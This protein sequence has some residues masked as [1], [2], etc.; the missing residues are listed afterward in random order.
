[1]NKC[2]PSSKQ[3]F[4]TI[5]KT[6]KEGKQKQQEKELSL[7][8]KTRVFSDKAP[9][10]LRPPL[11]RSQ[12]SGVAQSPLPLINQAKSKIRVPLRFNEGEWE[13]KGK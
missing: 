4:Q 8:N 11:L 2:S 12:A 13:T 1:M 10:G 3:K 7:I 6:D 5:E 9:L